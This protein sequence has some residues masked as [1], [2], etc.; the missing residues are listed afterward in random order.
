MVLLKLGISCTL[1]G[2]VIYA[3]GYAEIGRQCTD[4]K[5]EVTTSWLQLG[6]YIY[7]LGHDEDA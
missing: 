7:E 6:R 1:S 4:Y 3:L 2:L 5:L